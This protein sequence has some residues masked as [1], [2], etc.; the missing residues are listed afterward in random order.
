MVELADTDF[1]ES[2]R[3]HETKYF[4]DTDML[5]IA[6]THQYVPVKMHKSEEEHC[7]HVW[8]LI[9]F[10]QTQYHLGLKILPALISAVITKV[11]YTRNE[12]IKSKMTEL[13]KKHT[14]RLADA[15][16]DAEEICKIEMELQH[17]KEKEEFASVME[18]ASLWSLF[19]AQI[20]GLQS[21]GCL[22]ELDLLGDYGPPIYY[23]DC[24]RSSFSPFYYS[25]CSKSPSST[26]YADDLNHFTSICGLRADNDGTI[27][28]VISKDKQS[29]SSDVGTYRSVP[30][31]GVP[32]QKIDEMRIRVEA[33]QSR[34]EELRTL[35]VGSASA[36]A[37]ASQEVQQSLLIEAD[38]ADI[39]TRVRR[40]LHGEE[41][42]CSALE[43][44][45]ASMAGDAPL[46]GARF[47]L[48]KCIGL[49]QK[50][51]GIVPILATAQSW[52]L[53][54]TL[55][56]QLLDDLYQKKD[57]FTPTWC[58]LQLQSATPG[59]GTFTDFAL[60]AYVQEFSQI[61]QQVYNAASQA[62]FHATTLEE[63]FSYYAPGS[64]EYDHLC[65]VRSSWSKSRV[66]DCLAFLGK[67]AIREDYAISKTDQPKRGS[68][69]ITFQ[70]PPIPNELL[71]AA[72][73]L[74]NL[75]GSRLFSAAWNGLAEEAGLLRLR[76]AAEV[77]LTLYQQISNETLNFVAYESSGVAALLSEAEKT[78][79]ASSDKRLQQE[80]G[81]L[82][83]TASL[84]KL[85]DNSPQV[86]WGTGQV[87]KKWVQRATSCLLAWRHTC[88]VHSS[89][90]WIHETIDQL[91]SLCTASDPAFGACKEALNRLHT[92]D[93]GSMTL[94]DL[95]THTDDMSL[96][97]RRLVPC[98]SP[99]L[100]N[101]ITS[102]REVFEWLSKT[103]RDDKN[104]TATIEVFYSSSTQ[105]IDI[106]LLVR[107]RT[108]G[109]SSRLQSNCGRYSQVLLITSLIICETGRA[110]LCKFNR[111]RR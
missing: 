42:L 17:S 95:A 23:P 106:W 60:A 108:E 57:Q 39:W 86:V 100:M 98:V 105:A 40:L 6:R 31:F 29:L 70:V 64:T 83:S 46:V 96:V 85:Q 45:L 74:A 30:D 81:L 97:D 22:S 77:W 16:G 104:F 79:G 25:D 54:S 93:M 110:R 21:R 11:E 82:S 72:P 89:R 58:L 73:W 55:S 36:I 107:W 34:C 15:H 75:S 56:T 20:V 111:S 103:Q 53:E 43:Q 80:L 44:Q 69:P 47:E 91:E 52:L 2:W 18:K 27:W 99:D 4:H 84:L 66:C 68:K 37:S 62:K 12:R 19:A 67:D 71:D 35:D 13:S 32:K 87:D 24:S 88:N 94:K 76:P 14:R 92:L 63:V 102:H 3:F 48:D 38:V 90:P 33:A 78:G 51:L 5:H 8:T 7:C 61:L 49:E 28:H 59:V 65:Y 50:A 101:A 10:I 9:D 109:L 41:H 1:P 26:H